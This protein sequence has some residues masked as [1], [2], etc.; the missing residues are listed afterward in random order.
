ME[1]SFSSVHYIPQLKAT[2][3][4]HSDSA[5]I[6]R[7]DGDIPEK[8]IDER[9]TYIPWGGDDQLPYNVLQKIEEDET[10]TT[11]QQFNAEVCY[12]AGLAYNT[13][14]ATQAVK[15]EVEDFVLNNCLPSYYL[16]VCQDLKHFGFCVSVLYLSGDGKR[17]VAIARKEA[18][19]C[20]FTKADKQGQIHEVLYANWRRCVQAEDVEHI[21]LLNTLAPWYDLQTRMAVGTKC[22]KFAIVTRIPTPDSTYYPIPYYAALFKSKWYDIKQLIATAKKAKLENSAPIKYHIEVAD[23]Y[24]QSIFKRE[25]ITDPKKQIQRANEEKARIIDFLTGAE[26]AGKV[27]FSSYYITP[28]GKEQHDVVINN[29]DNSKE[30]GDWESD[31]QEAVNMICFT[32]GVHSNLVGSVPGKSQMNNSGS[33]KRELYTIAQARQKPYHDLLFIPHRIIIRFNRW[34]NVV[35]ECPFLMLTTLDEHTDAKKVNIDNPNS[36]ADTN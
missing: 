29:I 13:E 22:R 10:L 17:I 23:K 32:T 18:C 4:F 2:A 6:F 34:A 25:G 33:D 11:C 24:W 12:G 8:I 7:E 30:G 19:Y 15:D 14:K 35:P 3:I 27:W 31:I 21:S 28:D 36:H 16:G 1:I 20:R 9:T 5:A 26:N